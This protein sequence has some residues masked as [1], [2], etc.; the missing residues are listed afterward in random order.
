MAHD[1]AAALQRIEAPPFAS[2]LAGVGHFHA[3]IL[4]VGVAPNRA[5]MCLQDKVEQV[6]RAI[7]L[8][9][10]DRPYVPHVK[11]ARLRRRTSYGHFS[12]TMATFGPRHS[13]SGSSA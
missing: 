9:V 8:P 3:H 6:L 1:I 12:A 5:L 2:T 10:D 7:G 13:R 4:W 11:L